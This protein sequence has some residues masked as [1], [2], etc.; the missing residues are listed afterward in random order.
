MTQQTKKY[1]NN[2]NGFTLLFASL[3]SAL[4]LAVGIAILNVSLKQLVL[5][6]AGKASQQSFYSADSGIECALY[7]DRGAGTDCKVGFFGT[8]S[9]TDSGAPSGVSVCG[10]SSSAGTYT[11]LPGYECFGRE[12]S[13]SVGANVNNTVINKFVLDNQNPLA[14]ANTNENMCFVVSVIKKV[15]ASIATSTTIIESR[16]YNTCNPDAGERFERAI[17]T[18]NF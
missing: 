6:S 5:A 3:I 8:P 11:N 17:R 2:Q 10:I 9:T 14:N 1:L 15:N 18:V 12:I 4:V 13:I 7:L 16:G